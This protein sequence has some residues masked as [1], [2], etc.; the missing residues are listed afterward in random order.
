MKFSCRKCSQEV[1]PD[2][3]FCQN[4]GKKLP[5]KTN[6]KRINTARML[7]LSQKQNAESIRQNAD[8]IKGV[9]LLSIPLAC[10]ACSKD[11]DRYYP[12]AKLPDLPH[13][14]CECDYGCG[15]TLITDLV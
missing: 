3:Q 4:C 10:E 9:T 13:Q 15:C 7:A 12:L 14:G 2:W 6:Q 5:L 11:H 1:L 8:I